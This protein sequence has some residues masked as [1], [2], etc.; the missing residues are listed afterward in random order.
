MLVGSKATVNATVYGYPRPA[1]YTYKKKDAAGSYQT[2]AQYNTKT[3]VMDVGIGKYEV[4]GQNAHLTITKVVLSDG[5]DYQ[6]SDGGPTNKANFKL[7]VGCKYW[8]YY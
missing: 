6:V 8:Y 7:E 5:G 1:T 3:K 4:S 2:V